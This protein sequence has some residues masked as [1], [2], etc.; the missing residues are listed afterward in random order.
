M[1]ASNTQPIDPEGQA[2]MEAFDMAGVDP[3]TAYNATQ[4]LRRMS[5]TTAIAEIRAL[6]TDFQTHEGEFQAL[7]AD[8]QALTADVQALTAKVQAQS[9]DMQA[10]TAE[11]RAH[12]AVSE[13]RFN[14]MDARLDLVSWGVMATFGVVM[15]LAAMGLLDWFGLR[16]RRR[17]PTERGMPKGTGQE[18]SEHTP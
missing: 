10:L 18:D 9:A 11:L 4:A 15:L 1:P 16:P 17:E 3:E 7:S 14:A 6:R 13:I 2:V 8:V 12:E 5:E